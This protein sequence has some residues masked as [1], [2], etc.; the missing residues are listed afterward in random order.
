MDKKRKE[1]CQKALD[2]EIETSRDSQR[3]G[4]RQTNRK[5]ETKKKREKWR[6]KE[7]YRKRQRDIE[8]ERGGV[9]LMSGTGV[10]SEQGCPPPHL[11]S[12]GRMLIL[13]LIAAQTM[14]PLL[15]PPDLDNR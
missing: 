15:Q 11:L 2:T 13:G 1:H 3:D 6:Q 7:R 5:R 4:E 9:N 8:S 14:R 10:K 12:F